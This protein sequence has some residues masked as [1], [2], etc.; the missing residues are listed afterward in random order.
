MQEATQKKLK[1]LA[2]KWANQ[3][4]ILEQEEQIRRE[5][6]QIV[7][8]KKKRTT[9]KRY[10]LYLFGTCTLIELFTGYLM[11]HQMVLAQ[12]GLIAPDMSPQITLISVVVAEVVA[13]AIYAVK[14]LKE[15]TVGGV[16]YDMAMRNV[17]EEPTE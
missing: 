7:A 11:I 16:V 14:S 2:E 4:A 6:H 10:M 17:E 15:N 12:Q 9:T 5:K 8:E 13:F 1:K 3:K